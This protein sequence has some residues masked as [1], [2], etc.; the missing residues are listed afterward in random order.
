ML[1]ENRFP[2]KYLKELF[3]YFD[4]L[5]HTLEYCKVIKGHC[6][7]NDSLALLIPKLRFTCART[8]QDFIISGFQTTDTVML[9]QLQIDFRFFETR[10]FTREYFENFTASDKKTQ[11]TSY[12]GYNQLGLWKGVRMHQQTVW[13]VQGGRRVARNKG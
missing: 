8:L 1:W 13:Y 3:S 5:N 4:V 9:N 2:A 11:A 6:I 7:F 12:K 10:I